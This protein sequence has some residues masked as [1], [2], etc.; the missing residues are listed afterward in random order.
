[1]WEKSHL[2]IVKKIKSYCQIF[3][4]KPKKNETHLQ[5][6]LISEMLILKA[7][8]DGRKRNENS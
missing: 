6:M 8:T 2:F 3:V 4:Q 5:N 7:K 1:M